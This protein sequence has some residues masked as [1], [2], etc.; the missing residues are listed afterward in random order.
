MIRL[1]TGLPGSFKTCRAVRVIREAV[2]AGRPVFVT[3]LE[4]LSV[5][6]VQLWD[7]PNDWEALPEGALLVVDEAQRFWRASRSPE[8]PPAIVALETHRHKG[9]DFLLTTQQ[10]GYLLKHL[11][12]LVG[13]HVHHIRNGKMRAR[14]L[15]WNRCCVDLTS[16]VEAKKADAGFFIATADDFAYYTSTVK[17]THKPRLNRRY[18]LLAVAGVAIATVFG[19]AGKGFLWG[20]ESSDATAHEGSPPQ[21]PSRRGGAASGGSRDQPL[22]MQ[23]YVKLLRPRVGAAPWSAPIFDDREAVA[24]PEIFCISAAAGIDAEGKHKPASYTCLTEQGSRYELDEKTARSLARN[25]NMYNPFREPQEP[26]QALGGAGDAPA[27][28]PPLGGVPVGAGDVDQQAAYGAFRDS[29][30][31]SS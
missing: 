12:D 6:G 29:A 15:T 22:T 18:V 11:R 19:V 23:E 24:K 28:M 27:P 13:E 31:P 10:P 8:I 25:G 3:N 30:A 4:G 9:I 1:F 26:P 14:T 16:S 17:D 7:N 5:P 2:A 21:A 20:R